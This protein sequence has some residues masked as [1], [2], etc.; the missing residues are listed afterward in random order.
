MN[1]ADLDPGGID[2]LNRPYASPDFHFRHIWGIGRIVP[3]AA[4]VNSQPKPGPRTS[5]NQRN[6]SYILAIMGTL[7][8][9][10]RFCALG[11]GTG[12][13]VA[14]PA[15]AATF[16]LLASGLGSS[17]EVSAVAGTTA[18]GTTQDGGTASGGTL[19]SVTSAKKV[20]IL[21]SFVRATEGS[22]PND[23]LVVDPSGNIYG[24]TQ[25]GGKFNGGTIYEFTTGHVLKVVHAFDAAAGDGSTPL[26][27]L[28]RN[29]TG[30]LYGAAAGGAIST[31]GSVF[32]VQTSGVYATRYKFKSAGDGHCPYSSVAV[33]NQGNVY[34]TVV[35]GGFGGDPNGA[36]W[37]LSPQNKLTPLYLFKD[38]ADGEYPDQSPIV[39]TAGNLYGTIITK[40]DGQY[41]G[42]VWKIDT[43][44]KFSLLHKF[45]GTA[46]GFGPNG[47]LLMNT[48]GNLY[49]TTASGGG[50]VAKPGYG[51]LFRLTPAGAFT[52]IHTF[53]GPDGSNPTG[54]LAHDSTGAIYGA[55]TGNSGSIGGTV[56]KVKP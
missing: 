21:H 27:G 41:A 1:Q 25:Q 31:N 15:Y 3:M 29:G 34:G 22:V 28:V 26:Q 20:T 48:D 52:V 18:Y 55:T 54:T 46:D 35:G 45:T 47:P 32:E 53:T 2:G 38:G 23:M 6:F 51:T 19:F 42:A 37:K 10:V 49:G 39:D 56:Y 17:L 24:T 50:T 36:V 16:T 33:D 11:V 44:G 14:A 9:T 13:L 8:R 40:N 5:F 7:T 30:A 43:A 4:R 12:L